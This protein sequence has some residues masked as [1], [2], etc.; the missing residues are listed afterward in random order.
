MDTLSPL[1]KKA[2]QDFKEKL[3]KNFGTKLLSIRLFGSRAKG[4]GDEFS[5]L[6]VAVVVQ[7][8]DWPMK[9]E[10]FDLAWECYWEHNVDISPLVLSRQEMEEL[11]SL[12]RQIAKD[13]ETEGIAL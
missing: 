7:S 2:L 3:Q 5:D 11:K 9:R 4:E 10:I 6:D 8:W 13:I 12:E 1:E